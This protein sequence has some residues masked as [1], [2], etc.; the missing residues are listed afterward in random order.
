IEEIKAKSI[1]GNQTKQWA[2]ES[3][4]EIYKRHESEIWKHI[5]MQDPKDFD[6]LGIELESL[7]I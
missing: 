3:K 2:R 5:D 7:G 1:Q 6:N 4:A